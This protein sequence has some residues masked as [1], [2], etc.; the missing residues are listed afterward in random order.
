VAHVDT[1]RQDGNQ[2]ERPASGDRARDDVRPLS[3]ARL[4]RRGSSG[5]VPEIGL[6]AGR[7]RAWGAL[8]L[9]VVSLQTVTIAASA[10]AVCPCE[11]SPV[12]SPRPLRDSTRHG[13]SSP[14]SGTGQRARGSIW[15]EDEHA[16]RGWSRDDRVGIVGGQVG[17]SIPH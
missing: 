13:C 17:E 11:I 8:P 10:P 15:G 5:A 4:D 3:P 14:T 16:L 1:D 7:V 9:P 12:P 2:G 6:V